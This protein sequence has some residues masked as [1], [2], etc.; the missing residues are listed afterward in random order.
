VLALLLAGFA[1]FFLY[2]GCVDL[3]PE[4]QRAGQRIY[5]GF[6][7]LLGAGLLYAVTRI[8]L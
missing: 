8:V 1:G 6:A 4:S 5:A 2:L 3:L 7:T